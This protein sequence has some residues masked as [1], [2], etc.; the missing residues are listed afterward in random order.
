MGTAPA[1]FNPAEPEW[2]GK[3]GVFTRLDMPP[4]KSDMEDRVTA[5]KYQVGRKL[6]GDR[7][8]IVFSVHCPRK[9]Q[10][11]DGKTPASFPLFERVARLVL[12]PERSR[13][14][15][16]NQNSMSHLLQQASSGQYLQVSAIIRNRLIS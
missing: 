8:Q 1:S 16:I 7:H 11:R 6:V 4:G 13:I 2:V 10:M 9:W 3:T 12:Y 14:P 15:I 5:H